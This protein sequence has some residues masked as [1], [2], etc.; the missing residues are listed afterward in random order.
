MIFIIA[1]YFANTI[2]L[3]GLIAKGY[4]TITWGFWVV[5]VILVLTYGAFKIVQN[6]ANTI[7]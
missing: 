1:I 6:S 7:P 2:G 5:F 4:G 3:V